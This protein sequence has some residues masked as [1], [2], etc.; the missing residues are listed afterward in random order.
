MLPSRIQRLERALQISLRRVHGGNADCAIFLWELH[1]TDYYAPQ[2]A[3]RPHRAW[4]DAKRIINV[5]EALEAAEGIQHVRVKRP[6]KNAY[7][8]GEFYA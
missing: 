5:L 1:E 3:P 7:R 2:Y 6:L 4:Q 8:T